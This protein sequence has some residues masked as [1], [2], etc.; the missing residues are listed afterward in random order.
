MATSGEEVRNMQVILKDYV[1]GFP[2][3]SDMNVKTGSIKLKLAEDESSDSAVLV[4]NLYLSCD[5]Y[6]RGRMTN[7]P[8]DDPDFSPF[9]PGS[10]IVGHGV[11]ENLR[12]SSKFTLLM[13]PFPYYTG[14]LGMPGMTA[15][16]GFYQVCSPKKGERVYIS[17]ASGAVGQL[18]GQFAKLMG[19]YVVG[20]AGS[21]EKVELLKSKFGFDDAFN[22]KEEHDLVAALKRYFPEGIDIYFENVGGKMLDAV[23]LNM[24]FHGRIAAC[25]M[26]SQYN[27][28]QPEGIQNITTVVFKRIRLEGF[29]IFDYFDQYPKFLD[30]VLPYIREGKIV[31]V[32]DITE[33]LERGP[34][35]LIGLF[36]GRNVG[37]QVVKVT[38][39]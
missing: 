38:N 12:N 22:Y 3:E 8:V 24:R 31:Y 28:Q 20:S 35:A 11:A 37:K 15:Y 26:I 1:A 9:T 18:V 16:F 33:G 30:F 21:K 10:P 25:G 36:S 4:K 19:C 27:L 17:A 6:M 23:L 7:S 14:I 29:I 39:E 34:S 32:E 13:C 5:P 2:K